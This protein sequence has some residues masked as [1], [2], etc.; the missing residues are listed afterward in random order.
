ME[1]QVIE[2]TE[3][4]TI[5]DMGV[6]DYFTTPE[7]KAAFQEKRPHMTDLE[8]TGT[9][10]GGCKFCY[11][12]STVTND[13]FL[14]KEKAFHVIDDSKAMGIKTV[15]L[16]G[17]DPFLHPDWPEIVSYAKELEMD[18]SII[19]TFVSKSQARLLYSLIPDQICIHIDTID[20]ETFNKVNL[21]PNVL[22]K[23]LESLQNLLDA[24]FAPKSIVNI[25]IRRA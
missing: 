1:R 16:M 8:L 20:Q 12:G 15:Q 4:L 10:A 19:P 11:A 22:Q 21:Y 17:G 6:V 18:V 23:R 7:A 2:P 9:C 24:G 5:K 3:K 13:D 25:I 14:P